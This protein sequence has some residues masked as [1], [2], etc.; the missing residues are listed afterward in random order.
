MSTLTFP[1][2]AAF[3]KIINGKQTDLYLL[4]NA[5]GMKAFITNYGGRLVAL[6]VPD[7]D[8]NLVNVNLGLQSVEAYQQPSDVYY[9]AIVGRFANRIAKGKFTIDGKEYH[10]AINNGPNALHGG[11]GGFHQLVWEVKHHDPQ[12]LELY[13]LSKDGEEGFPGNLAVKVIYTLSD[14][15]EL[16]I[17]YEAETDQKTIINLTNHAYFNLN[18]EGNG[19]IL[20]HQLQLFA[21]QY[22]PTDETAIPY[23]NLENVKHTPFDF[24]QPTEIG[25]RI[26]EN[27][28]QLIFGNGYDHNYALGLEK[29]RNLNK[30]ANAKGD[31]T[32][33]VMEVF[34]SEPGF[35]F[36]TGN[37]MEGANTLNGG[38]K[39]NRRTG[40]CLETQHFPDSPNKTHFPSTLL[41]PGEV[42]RS[43]TIYQFSV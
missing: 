14:A 3:Q 19:D 9:G 31:L 43:T 13:Y 10:L 5:N 40:F 18:G 26:D 4:E 39:D 22:T 33:I 20:K 38:E 7:K 2:A 27:H 41:N 17:N 15:N 42:F 24:T 12:S 36:Y 1:E 32:G 21:N 8:G 37:Y 30:V 29:E 35:Q 23:G 16:H 34:T 11:D 6:Y 28:E 25:A